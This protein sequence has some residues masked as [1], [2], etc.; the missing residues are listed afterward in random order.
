MSQFMTR[1]AQVNSSQLSK[2]TPTFDVVGAV[3]ELE[4]ED[5]IDRAVGVQSVGVFVVADVAVVSPQDQ[6]RSVDEL[7]DQLLI[8][9][10]MPAH[11][12]QIYFIYLDSLKSVR[13][14][15]FFLLSLKYK[16]LYK[17]FVFIVLG[18]RRETG[19]KWAEKLPCQTQTSPH[20][21]CTWCFILH[22]LV[23]KNQ[24][25][26]LAQNLPIYVQ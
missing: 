20:T 10:Y 3:A 24:S 11:T 18:Q 9:T 5:V 23:L 19:R 21:M 6:N 22:I 26:H 25:S 15:V 16:V 14:L 7:Q 8:L 4:G 17:A 2:P 1:F 13:I 12:Q